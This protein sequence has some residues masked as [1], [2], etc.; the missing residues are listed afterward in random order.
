MRHFEGEMVELELELPALQ[1]EA[2]ETEAHSRGKSTGQIVRSL[3]DSYFDASEI[4][5]AKGRTD[6][7][8]S[9]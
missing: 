6:S 8:S 4:T 7:G 9:L 1:M 2:L 3:I 5:Q